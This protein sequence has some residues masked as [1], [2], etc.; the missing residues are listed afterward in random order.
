MDLGR[1]FRE[2]SGGEEGAIFLIE[3]YLLEIRCGM[4]EF[5]PQLATTE[6]TTTLPLTSRQDSHHVGGIWGRNVPRGVYGKLE[7]FAA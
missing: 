2:E 3:R 5:T 6:T 1:R 7:H 4:L